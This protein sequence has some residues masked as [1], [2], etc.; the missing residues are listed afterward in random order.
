MFLITTIHKNQFI[1]PSYIF[2]PLWKNPSCPRRIISDFLWASGMCFL[3]VC[4]YDPAA[5]CGSSSPSLLIVVSVILAFVLIIY[6][7]AC[8]ELHY[9]ISSE[10]MV[11]LSGF[12]FFHHSSLWKKQN[13]TNDKRYII[14]D[15]DQLTR[16]I[17]PPYSELLLR[18]LL[19]LK[20]NCYTRMKSRSFFFFCAITSIMCL[21]H[22]IYSMCHLL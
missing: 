6:L 4:E 5:S 20:L 2:W 19:T 18:K 1:F 16:P 12:F 10:N 11:I 13:S 9:M 22:W 21:I 15:R 3:C 8:K 7:L 17:L 14:T